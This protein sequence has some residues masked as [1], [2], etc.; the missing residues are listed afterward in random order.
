MKILLTSGL[1]GYSRELV[2]IYYR[3][4]VEEVIILGDYEFDID[5]LPF[6]PLVVK[7]NSLMDNYGRDFE[8]IKRGNI[9]FFITHG[10]SFGVKSGLNDLKKFGKEYRPNIVCFGHTHRAEILKDEGITY[11]NPGSLIKPWGLN[12]KSYMIL[13]IAE[14][15]KVEL[16]DI[17][18]NL[19]E[20]QII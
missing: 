12:K 8:V 6:E 19:I 3:T 18:G 1:H 16:F 5:I 20:E 10:H 9:T 11:L 4:A 17:A 13:T 14:E 2:A 7:G 15:T